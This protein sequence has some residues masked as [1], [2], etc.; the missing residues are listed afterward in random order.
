[1]IA[2][3]TPLLLLTESIQHDPAAIGF[4]AATRGYFMRRLVVLQGRA[5]PGPH[6]IMVGD[7]LAHD[8]HLHPDGTLK[9]RN[10]GFAVA[11]IYHSGILFEDTGAIMSLGDAQALAHRPAEETTV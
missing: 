11:G 6:Q 3:A 7:R 1:Y 5:S 9:V 8:Q 10:R 4:G 2:D